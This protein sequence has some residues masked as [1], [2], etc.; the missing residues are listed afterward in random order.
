MPPKLVIFDCDGVLVDSEGIAS[1]VLAENLSG[2]GY[3]VTAPECVDLFV[4]GTMSSIK[5]LV[6]SR[7]VPLPDDWV[8][9]VYRDIYAALVHQVEAVPGVVDVLDLLDALGVAYCVASNGRTEKMRITLGRN[10]MFDRFQGR[11]YS[12]QEM[13]TAK[14]A[15]DMFLKAAADF[16]AAPAECVVIEDSATGARA[17]LAAGMPCFGYALEHPEKLQA[18]G[19]PIFTDMADLPALLGLPVGLR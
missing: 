8:E 3:P 4:G 7:G 16:G 14:P 10:G 1:A 5:P 18:L 17:A 6:E 13:G 12:A 2:H 15:P 19:V 11:M 9:A